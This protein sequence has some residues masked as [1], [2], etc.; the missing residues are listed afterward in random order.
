MRHLKALVLNNFWRSDQ[1]HRRLFHFTDLCNLYK[2]FCFH[3]CVMFITETL[4]FPSHVSCLTDFASSL[5]SCFVFE[6]VKRSAADLI[7]Q[8]LHGL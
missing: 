5:L 1:V 4:F 3:R 2:C 7:R 8:L 6:Q